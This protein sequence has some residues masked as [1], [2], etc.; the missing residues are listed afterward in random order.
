MLFSLLRA[1]KLY[2]KE[3][4]KL[5]PHTPQTTAPAKPSV[6]NLSSHVLTTEQTS[7][8]ELGLDFAIPPRSLP[9][10][11]II[12]RT[13]MWANTLPDDRRGLALAT[14]R[15]VHQTLDSSPPPGSNLSKVHA[16][17][18][19]SLRKVTNIKILPA[20]K[21]NAVVLVDTDDYDQ[22]IQ[23]HLND[24]TTYTTLTTDPT[25]RTIRKLNSLLQPLTRDETLT[26]SFPSIRGP[27]PHHIFMDCQKFTKKES[28]YGQ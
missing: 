14:C 21:G 24:T 2:N 26:K 13:E 15:I 23:Q 16:R 8:L 25:D 4:K 3:L 20:D 19:S 6:I 7:L 11:E 9:I 28:H 17:A 5:K 1:S 18:L 22:K 12:T 10:E 27:A